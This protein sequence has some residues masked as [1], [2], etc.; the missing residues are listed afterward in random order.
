MSESTVEKLVYHGIGADNHA[1]SHENRIAQTPTTNVIWSGKR[2]MS[3]CYPTD[4]NSQALLA[5]YN[6]SYVSY[7]LSGEP[8]FRPF[9][10]A[11]IKISNM[12]SDRSKNFRSA[13]EKLLSTKYAKEHG[14]TTIAEVREYRQKNNLTYHENSDSVTID[15]V[16][17]EINRRYG[18]SG[19]VAERK[20]LE[21]TPDPASDGLIQ[22]ARK[23]E[24]NAKVAARQSGVIISDHLEQSIEAGKGAAGVTLIVSGLNNMAWVA[25]GEKDFDEAAKDILTDTA[26]SF[27]SAAGMEMS[28][29]LVTQFATNMGAT[30]LA[31]LA[32]MPL[33]TQQIALASM[34]A[35]AF[36]NYLDGNISI[37]DC[38]FQIFSNGLGTLA[39]S[40]GASVGGPVGG[41]LASMVTAQITA[42]IE[43]YRQEKKIQKARDTEISHVLSWAQAEAA[44]QQDSF[45]DYVES[46]LGRWDAEIDQGFHKIMNATLSNDASGI[47]DGLDRIMAL[48]G[49]Q[50]KYKNVS[51]F[52]KDFFSDTPFVLTL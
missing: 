46:E 13:D 33:P 19:G 6:R 18:H 30:K 51:E 47:A 41:A 5:Q 21:K 36:V 37:Q 28:R 48:F 8:D 3:R 52:K 7:N 50:V 2:G 35:N 26:S 49:K 44:Q 24:A 15:L 17:T 11:T 27:V 38:A 20:E 40:L 31:Q 45:R 25:A 1:V 12:S 14:L 32:S 4:A 34:T 29:E 39:Y 42:T 22:T 23:A 9:A 43:K 16:P 10:E